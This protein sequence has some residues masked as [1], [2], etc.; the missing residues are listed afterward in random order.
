MNLQQK[1]DA[2]FYDVE[3]EEEVNRFTNALMDIEG[4]K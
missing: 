3:S 4:L 1:N 2:Q